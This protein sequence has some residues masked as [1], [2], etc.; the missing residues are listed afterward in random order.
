MME[1][2][3]ARASCNKKRKRVERVC[4]YSSGLTTNYGGDGRASSQGR[5]FLVLALLRET[6]NLSVPG[7]GFFTF[8]MM[9]SR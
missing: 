1:D 8:V 7:L 5:P 2:L 6:R 9:E 4:I 3:F